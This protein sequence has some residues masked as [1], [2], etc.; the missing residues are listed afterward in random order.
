MDQLDSPTLDETTSTQTDQNLDNPTAVTPEPKSTFVQSLS[1]DGKI[2]LKG[3]VSKMVQVD[4]PVIGT[5]DLGEQT[6]DIMLAKIQI[7]TDDQAKAAFLETQEIKTLDH[8]DDMGG[9]PY[10]LYTLANGNQI[11]TLG[12]GAG[13]STPPSLFIRQS[14]QADPTLPFYD[15][16]LFSKTSE[17]PFSTRAEA[18]SN[19]KNAFSA[20]GIDVADDYIGYS[21]DYQTM[22]DTNKKMAEEFGAN[23]VAGYPGAFKNNWSSEDN[24]YY[25]V[26]EQEMNGLPIINESHGDPNV[27]YSEGSQLSALYSKNGIEDASV[28]FTYTFISI[29][30]PAVKTISLDSALSKLDDTLNQMIL[31]N[32]QTVRTIKYGYLPLI[33]EK[34]TENREM[35]PCW[36][37][38]I[39]SDSGSLITATWIFINAVTGEEIQ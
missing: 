12:Y 39:M 15:L 5:K 11:Y 30:Q 1:D 19:I 17:W 23:T 10:S 13:Y 33:P 8:K 31:S 38:Q 9:S 26:F 7:I 16:D 3:T 28:L 21:L 25:F 35:V 37:F 34:S 29:D 14:I 18:I 20:M 24:C 36:A 32:T 22:A 27:R 2:Y 6:S 4:A